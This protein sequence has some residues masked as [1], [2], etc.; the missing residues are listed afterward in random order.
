M[1]KKNPIPDDRWMAD[2]PFAPPR[3]SF[4][5]GGMRRLRDTL[6]KLSPA[7]SA[8][9]EALKKINHRKSPLTERNI[10]NFVLDQELRDAGN[11]NQHNTELQVSAWLDKLS[12]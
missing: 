3:T 6:S 11:P 2:K 9:R 7:A 5:G 1:Q 10:D 4:P 8:E 12:S